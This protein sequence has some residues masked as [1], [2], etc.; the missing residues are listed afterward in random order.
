MASEIRQLSVFIE[1]KPGRLS[2]V[3]KLIGESGIDI[4]AMNIADTNDFGILRL[5]LSDVDKAASLLKE[6]EYAVTITNVIAADVENTP[7]GLA[8]ALSVLDTEGVSVEYMYASL[9]GTREAAHVV[10]RVDDNGKA[11]EALTSKGYKL[12][13]DADIK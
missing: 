9:S 11:S 13:G 8:G 12:I 4:K 5:I 1:N 7:G 10:I 2:K 6:K 3:L